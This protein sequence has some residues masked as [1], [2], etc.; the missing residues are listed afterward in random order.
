[1]HSKAAGAFIRA[2]IDPT[3]II[4]VADVGTMKSII[5]SG[6]AVEKDDRIA[7]MPVTGAPLPAFDV[8]VFDDTP[9]RPDVHGRK[10]GAD[11]FLAAIGRRLPA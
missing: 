8:Y 11:A 1:M 7:F 10:P 3:D 9:S 5:A 6:I 2:H 4:E